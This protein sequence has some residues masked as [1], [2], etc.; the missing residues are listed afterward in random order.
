[1]QT[2]P[3]QSRGRVMKTIYEHDIPDSKED[4]TFLMRKGANNRFYN[5]K[6]QP[7]WKPNGITD[8]R[9]DWAKENFWRTYKVR[10]A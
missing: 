7:I 8:N 4:Q 9:K 10:P 1:M 6:L 5:N 3:N 2:S